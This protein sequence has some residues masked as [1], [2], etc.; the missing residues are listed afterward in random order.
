M[1]IAIMGAGAVGGLLAALLHRAEQD[2]LLVGR[3]GS[4]A[5]VREAGLRVS[6]GEFGEW[7]SAVPASTELPPGADVVVAVK[8][9]GLRDVLPALAAARPRQVLSLLNGVTHADQVRAAVP[10]V[11]VTGAAVTVEV[12]RPQP[13]VIEHRSPFLRLA[14]PDDVLPWPMVR[15]IADAGVE[16]Q[17]GGTEREV[18]WRKFRFLAPMALLTSYWQEPLGPALEHEPQLT[19]DLVAEVARIATLEGLVTDPDELRGI[20]GSMPA[21][22][23]SSLQRDL[24]AGSEGELDALGGT[25]LRLAQQHGVGTPAL[26]RVHSALD[27]ATG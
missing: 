13:G 5:A 18:L 3:P 15:A 16:V 11:P 8:D 20:L 6:S 12:L 2:V 23:R 24:A 21:T 27:N 26:S 17:A 14:V 22:M 19:S 4:I 10:E 25:L 7:T 1:T 9:G